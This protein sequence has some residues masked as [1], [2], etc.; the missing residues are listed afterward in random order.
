M[1]PVLVKALGREAFEP[2]ANEY[3]R[4]YPPSSYTLN[5]LADQF[6]EFLSE[7]RPADIPLPEWP[8]FLIELARLEQT[9]DQV[10]DGPGNE[11]VPP[12]DVSGLSQLAPQNLA[13]LRFTPAPCLRL[14]ANRFP[15]NDYYTA[16]R[17]GE[18]S[19][20]PEPQA[21]WL[22]ITR[23]DFVVRRVPLEPLEYSVLAELV[24]GRTLS[25]ALA[26]SGD[27]SLAQIAAWFADWGRLRLFSAIGP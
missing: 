19:E 24:A 27:I 1:F 14:L 2:F 13:E 26:T 17:A 10:F 23:R 18:T 25:Q 3:L 9:I 12:L 8:D 15:I 4:H 7:T 21:T 6:V 22:A 11:N 20:Y 16:C 5:R